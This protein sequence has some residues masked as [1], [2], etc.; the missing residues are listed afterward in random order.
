MADMTSLTLEQGR[1]PPPPPPPPLLPYSPLSSIPSSITLPP[2]SRSTSASLFLILS[3]RTVELL[4]H[5]VCVWCA[6]VCIRV[7][8][9]VC[10]YV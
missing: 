4:A 2:F 5:P 7:C 8:V 3:P 9:R 10:V 1:M 6:R